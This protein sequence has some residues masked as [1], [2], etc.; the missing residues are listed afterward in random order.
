[1]DLLKRVAAALDSEAGY[2][3][4]QPAKPRQTPT[5]QQKR[6][7]VLLVL[8]RKHAAFKKRDAAP[9]L[10]LKALDRII[11]LLRENLHYFEKQRLELVKASY[12]EKGSTVRR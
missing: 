10:T 6:L 5:L 1:M 7:H 4:P 3:E 12:K 2:D 9:S 8:L 11:H